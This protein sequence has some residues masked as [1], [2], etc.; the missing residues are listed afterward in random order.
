ML[1]CALEGHVSC[2]SLVVV[3]GVKVVLYPLNLDTNHGYAKE[4]EVNSEL[5]KR[6]TVMQGRVQRLE[7]HKCITRTQKYMRCLPLQ[8]VDTRFQKCGKVMHFLLVS[9]ELLLF[10]I[11]WHDRL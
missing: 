7:Q 6:Q 9:F 2:S 10:Y 11:I 5:A 1:S 3:L 8:G 4:Q